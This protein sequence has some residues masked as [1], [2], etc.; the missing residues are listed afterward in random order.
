MVRLNAE[1]RAVD[2]TLQ[3]RVA[4]V[5]QL[6]GRAD[7]LVVLEERPARVVV[8]GQGEDLAHQYALAHFLETQVWILSS[9]TDHR[10]ASSL[11]TPSPSKKRLT[12]LSLNSIWY[13]LM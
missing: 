2:I 3:F 4:Q 12:T 8:A 9:G 11:T 6:V 13:P 10:L 5:A 1:F 7:Q